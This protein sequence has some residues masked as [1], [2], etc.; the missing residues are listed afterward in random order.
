MSQKLQAEKRETTSRGQLQS[1]RRQGKVPGIV[2][3]QGVKESTPITVDAKDVQALLR[4]NP[5][6]VLELEVPGI[7]KKNVMLT[8]VQ[9]DALS[10]EVLHIDFHKINMNQSVTVPVRIE[11]SG[12]SAGEKEGGLLQLVLHEVEIECLPKNLPEAI[13]IDVTALQIGDNLTVGDIRLPD[14]VRAALDADTVV[15]AVLAP[16]K[17]RTED[18]VEAMDDASEEAA[19]QANTGA[20]VEE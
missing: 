16:Q 18:E 1:I 17:E 12:K 11:V 6:A 4:N 20:K 10:R 13:T 15:I 5:R 8:D 7:G 9:R 14:G 2:Y 19:S 3:G